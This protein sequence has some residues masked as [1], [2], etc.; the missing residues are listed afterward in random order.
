LGLPDYLAPQARECT[1]SFDES[2]II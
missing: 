1:L 2:T